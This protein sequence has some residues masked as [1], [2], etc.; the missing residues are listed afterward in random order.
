MHLY[1]KTILSNYAACSIQ[2]T[3]YPAILE[4]ESLE[5]AMCNIANKDPEKTE[6]F[7]TSTIAHK[8]LDPIKDFHHARC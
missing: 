6:G 5:E 2:H 8:S 3:A 4:R 7:G 1:R